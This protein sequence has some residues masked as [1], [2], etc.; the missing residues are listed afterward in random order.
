[1]GCV[2]SFILPFKKSKGGTSFNEN[3]F[4]NVNALEQFVKAISH[5]WATIEKGFDLE[6]LV[7]TKFV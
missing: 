5:Q 4:M 1:M 7:N 2:R 6:N 3:L